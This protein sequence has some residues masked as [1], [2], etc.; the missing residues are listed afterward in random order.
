MLPHKHI[1]Y[2]LSYSGIAL[3]VIV[4]LI[5]IPFC[6]NYHFFSP[7]SCF[8]EAARSAP[9]LVLLVGIALSIMILGS[10]LRKK[11]HGNKF[12]ANHSSTII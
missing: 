9:Y 3:I 4:G 8:L 12:N 5:T 1:A 6:Q 11:W 10:V 7:Y 2:L